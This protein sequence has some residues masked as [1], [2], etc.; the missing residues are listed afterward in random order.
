MKK[1]KKISKKMSKRGFK[2]AARR[3]HKRNLI[4]GLGKRGGIML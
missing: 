4:R 2:Y 1:H 3:V